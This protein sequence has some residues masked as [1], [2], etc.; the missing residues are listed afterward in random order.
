MLPTALGVQIP[1]Q[2]GDVPGRGGEMQ[3]TWAVLI[4]SCAGLCSAQER[5]TSERIPEPTDKKRLAS[6]TWDLKDHKL[7]WTVEKGTM[8]GGEFV[9]AGSDRYETSPDDAM[10]QFG[11]EKRGFAEEEAVSL[12]RL[13]D[14]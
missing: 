3:K 14:T 4:L 12:H 9:P 5:K 13:L 2:P 1:G 10:M 6:V 8:Q 7:V 11:N